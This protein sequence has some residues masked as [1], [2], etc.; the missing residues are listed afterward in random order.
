MRTS[1]LIGEAP[2]EYHEGPVNPM[3]AEVERALF[4]YRSMALGD[5]DTP[6][7]LPGLAQRVTQH[8]TIG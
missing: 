4:T 6:A 1:A 5:R 3:L 7:E 2:S 8:G